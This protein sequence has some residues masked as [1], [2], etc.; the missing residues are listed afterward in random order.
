MEKKWKC[1]VH[2]AAQLVTFEAKCA[3]TKEA[4]NK[5]SN[6]TTI[7]ITITMTM[8]GHKKEMGEGFSQE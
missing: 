5:V 4:M 1:L 2:S 7:T 8:K 6:D 3:L